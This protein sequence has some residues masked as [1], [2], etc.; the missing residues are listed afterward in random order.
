MFKNLAKAVRS[1][2]RV[3]ITSCQKRIQKTYNAVKKVPVFLRALCSQPIK[4]YLPLPSKERKQRIIRDRLTWKTN[5]KEWRQEAFRQIA[6]PGILLSSWNQ[7]PHEIR[8]FLHRKMK[9]GHLRS[10]CLKADGFAV[11]LHN[12]SPQ[13]HVGCDSQPYIFYQI[14]RHNFGKKRQ[15]MAPRTPGRM[16]FIDL[17]H[18]VQQARK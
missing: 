7:G 14:C 12:F 2:L 16:F 18:F 11:M 6:A 17:R 4:Q 8:T 3:V 9:V 13:G 10:P 1:T 5:Q 15:S